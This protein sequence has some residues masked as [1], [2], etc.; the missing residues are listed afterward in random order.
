MNNLTKDQRDSLS[1]VQPT[2]PAATAATT[3]GKSDQGATEITL[4]ATDNGFIGTW[5]NCYINWILCS[6]NVW[7]SCEECGCTRKET[8]E[9]CPPKTEPGPKAPQIQAFILGGAPVTDPGEYPYMVNTLFLESDVRGT[10]GYKNKLIFIDCQGLGKTN[11][12]ILLSSYGN[13]ATNFRLAT[14]GP[15]SLSVPSGVVLSHDFLTCG[16]KLRPLYCYDMNLCG[17][18]VRR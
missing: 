9:S 8:S 18:G 14:F 16:P 7:C 2:V 10:P 3:P 12:A 11:D 6:N 17:D 1:V 13:Q 15:A 4:R 5:N